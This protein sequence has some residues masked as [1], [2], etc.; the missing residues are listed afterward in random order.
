MPCSEL[1]FKS[2]NLKTQFSLFILRFILPCKYECQPTFQNSFQIF[3]IKFL[4]LIQSFQKHIALV[5]FLKTDWSYMFLKA[6]NENINL[7]LKN[8]IG[9]AWNL[10][11]RGY[12]LAVTHFVTQFTH[13]LRH[14]IVQYKKQNKF[15][16]E[17]CFGNMVSEIH[18]KK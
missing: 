5:Y 6:S 8:K 14:F 13:I 4:F 9:K 15:F 10:I 18:K 1:N 7:N 17:N 3:P 12:I 16:W 11:S 2:K